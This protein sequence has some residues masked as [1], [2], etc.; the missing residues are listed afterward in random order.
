M[1]S[2]R[3]HFVEY[4]EPELGS[5]EEEFPERAATCFE[6]SPQPS[7]SH[8]N[9]SRS[10]SESRAR[11]ASGTSQLNDWN[12]SLSDTTVRGARETGKS[13]LHD[14]WGPSSRGSA[15]DS[16][17]LDTW[18]HDA[19]QADTRDY[20]PSRGYED[21]CGDTMSMTS[22]A[23]SAFGPQ[24]RRRTWG[25]AATASGAVAALARAAS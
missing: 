12:D 19:Q 11:D 21:E 16:T 23:D 6:E 9:V 10:E 7:S 17:Y 13:A 22:Y 5:Y 14:S 24:R 20:T 2:P 4:E 8:S 3:S 18:R 1:A 15:V 25:T